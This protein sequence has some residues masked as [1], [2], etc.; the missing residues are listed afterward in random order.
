MSLIGSSCSGVPAAFRVT[1]RQGSRGCD[2]QGSHRLVIDVVMC[3]P[4]RAGTSPDT[5]TG[6][7]VTSR[8]RAHERAD[9]RHPASVPRTTS[10][11]RLVS[12]S[13]P[14]GTSLPV[15]VVN[16]VLGSAVAGTR[17]ESEFLGTAYGRPAAVH[18][19]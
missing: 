7:R 16:D 1:R 13:G 11:G 8:A 6:S 5:G 18:A 10:L 19:E 12:E 4:A 15:P 9:S 17:H 3:P 14:R 2:E